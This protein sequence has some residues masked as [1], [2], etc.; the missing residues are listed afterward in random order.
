MHLGLLFRVC[1]HGV[2]LLHV[3]DHRVWRVS[4]G[5]ADRVAQLETGIAEQVVDFDELVVCADA[6]PLSSTLAIEV[7]VGR[8]VSSLVFLGSVHEGVRRLVLPAGLLDMV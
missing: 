7:V 4:Q 1:V 8:L 5:V 2:A 6:E 3:E